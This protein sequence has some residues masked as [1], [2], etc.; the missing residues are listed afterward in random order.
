MRKPILPVLL[1][2]FL[3]LLEKIVIFCWKNYFFRFGHVHSIWVWSHDLWAKTNPYRVLKS[4]EYFQQNNGLGFFQFILNF[5]L[6]LKMYLNIEKPWFLEIYPIFQYI[7]VSKQK[8]RTKIKKQEP[9]FVAMGL[10][11]LKPVLFLF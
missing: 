1:H 7:I 2:I 5:L 6:W 3:V 9:F 10:A 8:I 11:I 4:W